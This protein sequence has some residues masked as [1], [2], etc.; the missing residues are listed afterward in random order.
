MHHY[1]FC[2]SSLYKALYIGTTRQIPGLV[3]TRIF[4]NEFNYYIIAYRRRTIWINEDQRPLSMSWI[5]AL[6]NDKSCKRFPRS[7]NARRP[8]HVVNGFAIELKIMIASA[9]SYS[10]NRN[11]QREI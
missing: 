6:A 10:Q 9:H 2:G 3:S 5:H 4:L 1:N 7:G 11:I 8:A